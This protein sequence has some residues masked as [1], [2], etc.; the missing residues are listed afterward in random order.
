[1]LSRHQSVPIHAFCASLFVSEYDGE[2]T[3]HLSHYVDGGADDCTRSVSFESWEGGPLLLE[4]LAEELAV[5]LIS[6]V[7]HLH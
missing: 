7:K 4:H 1:M 5:R 6:A 3:A 2:V